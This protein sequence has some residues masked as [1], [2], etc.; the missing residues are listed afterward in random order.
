[1]FNQFSRYP[2]FSPPRFHT[3]VSSHLGLGNT[4][5][6]YDAINRLTLYN[7]LS[8]MEPQSDNLKY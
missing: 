4:L 1:M 6:T 2:A 5:I 7:K 8:P 3:T